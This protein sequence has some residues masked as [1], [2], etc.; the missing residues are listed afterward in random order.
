MHQDFR[1]SVGGGMAGDQAIVCAAM[2]GMMSGLISGL[3][4]G[5]GDLRDQQCR[6]SGEPDQHEQTL[7]LQWSPGHARIYLHINTLRTVI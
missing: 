7:H 1:H 6:Q 3:M 2:P 5:L 4:S